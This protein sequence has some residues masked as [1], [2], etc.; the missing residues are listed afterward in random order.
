MQKSGDLPMQAEEILA[1]A[2][3]KNVVAAWD[4]AHRYTPAPRHRRRL[5]L[6]MLE[7]LDFAEC[8]DTGCAQPFL[9]REIM[10]RY[11]VTGYGCDIS[12]QVMEENQR[13]LPEAEFRVLDLTKEV[14]PNGRQF[15]LVVCSEVLEHIEDWQDAVANLVKMTRTHLLITVPSG[16]LRTMDQLVGHRQHFEHPVLASVL[17]RC[18]CKV[19]QVRYWGFP[20]HSLYKG[21]ISKLSPAK[22]YS[23]FS[24][25]TSYGWAKRAF[26]EVLYWSFFANDVGNSGNQLLIH[27][28]RR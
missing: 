21:L 8:L 11:Q 1:V 17:E 10:T 20:L 9:L 13:I 23:S 3:E 18:G 27:A 22:L 4:D 19:R 28:V 25:V 5:I 26:S 24:G 14:W 2:N 16:R 15:D 6:R 7:G 12:D